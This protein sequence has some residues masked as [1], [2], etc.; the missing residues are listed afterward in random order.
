MVAQALATRGWLRFPHDARLQAWVAAALPLARQA[1][2][3]SAEFWRCGGTWFVGVD[4]LDNDAKGTVAGVAFLGT[5]AETVLKM[6]GPQIFHRAQ[7]STTRPGYPQASVE[8]TEA[9]F[10]YR[11]TRDAAHID[12]I[13]PIGPDRR[14]MI[15]EPH[16]FVLGIPL[17]TTDPG[18]AP[19]VVW[20]GSQKIIARAFRDALAPHDPA[21]WPDIDVTEAYHAARAQ[22]FATCRRRVLPV[23]PGEAILLHRH[24]LHGVS[25]WAEGAAAPPEGR[26]I[27][28]FRPELASVAAWLGE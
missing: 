11:K 28:Y 21:R 5:A 6:F 4:A 15:R 22:V 24:L 20:E 9:A 26:I 14:R 1:I 17:T 16:A 23:T 8:E 3:A 19:L 10:R 25:P 18:A 7:L 27:A 13:L 2:A 12:G